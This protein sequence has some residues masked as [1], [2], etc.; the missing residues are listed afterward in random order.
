M[1]ESG[2]NGNKDD[3]KISVI[4]EPLDDE[5]QQL[6]D[7]WVRQD[8]TGRREISY[9]DEVRNELGIEEDE[10]DESN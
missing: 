3:P 9:G 7:R 5:T 2:G 10:E 1:V 6:Q 4:F 8:E